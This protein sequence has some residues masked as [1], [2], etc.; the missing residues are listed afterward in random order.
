MFRL[1][2]NKNRLMVK[3]VNKNNILCRS[4]KINI[5]IRVI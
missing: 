2:Q 1:L 3:K 5:L 4:K